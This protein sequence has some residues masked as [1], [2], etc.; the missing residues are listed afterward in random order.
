MY[1]ETSGQTNERHTSD[2]QTDVNTYHAY[3]RQTDRQTSIHID[4]YTFIHTYRVQRIYRQTYKKQTYI[5]KS[6]HT[7]RKSTHH[8]RGEQQQGGGQD[9]CLQLRPGGLGVCARCG[10]APGPWHRRARYVCMYVCM[11]VCNMLLLSRT[12]HKSR[13]INEGNQRNR[14]NLHFDSSL[15]RLQ[16]TTSAS[17]MTAPSTSSSSPPRCVYL[18]VCVNRSV[19]VCMYGWMYVP[20]CLSICWSLW[21]YIDL[22]FAVCSSVVSLCLCFCSIWT[23]L[24]CLAESREPHSRQHHLD[25]RRMLHVWMF[26]CSS[27]PTRWPASSCP[28]WLPGG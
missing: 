15:D 4:I 16:W 26:T 10:P 21:Y 19:R 7:S 17:P 8:R 2:I 20:I 28:A 1:R 13:A 18:F 5:Q 27:D 9:Y 22:S 12:R 14:E 23:L 25:E 6:P 3:Y 11:Y 24:W